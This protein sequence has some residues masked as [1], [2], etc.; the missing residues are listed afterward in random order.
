[1]KKSLDLTSFFEG[2]Q[3]DP[4]NVMASGIRQ[5][6]L[7]LCLIYQG[8]DFEGHQNDPLHVMTPGI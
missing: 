4:L 2:Y 3:K 1:M 7:T 5:T 8:I 6:L